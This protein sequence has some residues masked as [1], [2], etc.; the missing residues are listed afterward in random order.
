MP[1]RKAYS[2]S[3]KL[4]IVT[5]IR[6]GESRSKVC[7]E[8]GLAESTLRGW[9]KEEAKLREFADSIDD[10][11]GLT[12]KRARTAQDPALDSQ[13][14][15]WFVRARSEGVPVSGPILMSQAEKITQDLHGSDPSTSTPVS[16]GWLDR[17]KSR[18]SIRQVRVC[19]EEKSADVAA[20]VDFIPEFQSFLEENDYSLEQIYNCDETALYY[21]TVPEKTL[22]LPTERNVKGYKV[23]KDRITLLFCC[24]WAGSHKT[25]PLMIGKFAKPRCFHHLNMARLPVLYQNSKNAWMTGTI[26]SQW[27]HQDFVPSVKKHLKKQKLP[28]K[29]VLLL[30]N[31]PAHPPAATLRS[32]DGKITVHYLPKNTTSKIKPLDQGIIHNFKDFYRSKLTRSFLLSTN[33]SLPDFLK[34]TN[35]KDATDLIHQAWTAVTQKT[36][37]N[38]NRGL[39]AALPD[40]SITDHPDSDSDDEEFLGFTQQEI[41][42]LE[43]QLDQFKPNQS[44]S[45]TSVMTT[46]AAIDTDVPTVQ[47]ADEETDDEEEEPDVEIDPDQSSEPPVPRSRISTLEAIRMT[48]EI[49]YWAE[50]TNLSKL[51]IIQCQDLVREAKQQHYQSGKQS[52]IKDFF[53]KK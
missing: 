26:F 19:G 4:S 27:F 12:R 17:W 13:V 5:R 8:L 33:P 29:A 51:K 21:K 38:W 53:T 40:P 18:H 44:D 52:S 32:R 41:Q 49:L 11:K 34:K 37:T 28:Q 22:A 50:C 35:L 25:T 6:N 16:R 48:E 1:K 7:R 10:T 42:A 23:I 3:D 15:D 2:V 31:C 39:A 43:K 14:Y 36:I 46:W 20:A 24:N 30:D 9:L 45:V 47:P